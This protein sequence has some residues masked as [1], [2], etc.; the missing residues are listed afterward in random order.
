VRRFLPC[1]TA[2]NAGNGRANVASFCRDVVAT[3]NAFRDAAGDVTD[4]V[5]AQFKVD[6]ERAQ[7]EAPSSIRSVV[8]AMVAAVNTVQHNQSTG[9]VSSESERVSSWA[10]AHCPQAGSGSA[11]P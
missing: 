2:P 3:A 6:L 9:D 11:A 7:S 5:F 8:D 1:A 10:D 4:P